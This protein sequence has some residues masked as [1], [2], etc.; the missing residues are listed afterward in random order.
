M[1]VF[2]GSTNRLLSAPFQLT[3]GGA[4]TEPD[5][6]LRTWLG[7]FDGDSHDDI[8]A[9]A[10]SS[11]V[12]FVLRGWHLPSTGEAELNEQSAKPSAEASAGF[13]YCAAL[14]TTID[15]GLQL[16]TRGQLARVSGGGHSRHGAAMSTAS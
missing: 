6:A 14:G 5:V 12:G 3:D 9:L 7:D 11:K 15:L 13:D 1:A 2:L 10:I 4:G 16:C 8:G